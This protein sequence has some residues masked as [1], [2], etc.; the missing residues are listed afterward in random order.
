MKN[1]VIGHYEAV[2]L[3]TQVGKVLR[4]LGN[5]EPP[6]DLRTVREL[7]RLDRQYY[8]AAD[9]GVA[10]EVISYLKIAGKQIVARPTLLIDVIRK[11][12][13]AALWMPDQKRI[14]LDHD[15]PVLKH[16]WYESHE[17]GH[18]L[19][20]WHGEFLYGDSEETLSPV[21]RE[22]LEAEANYAAGQLLFMMDRFTAEAS[23]AAPTI[24]TVRQ[25][26]KRFGNTITSTLWR[27]VE[28]AHRGR[29]LFGVVTPSRKGAASLQEGQQGAR[30]Y[31]IEAPSFRERFGHSSER[32]LSELIDGYVIPRRGGPLGRAE[33]V[34]RDRNGDCHLFQFETFSNGHSLLT[35]GVYLR[36]VSPLVP[37]P[38]M[39]LLA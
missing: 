13:L 22:E 20:P 12:E 26:A 10:R 2:D 19:A 31:C 11:A 1:L 30:R 35:L 24:E 17:I 37:V 16:R 39:A 5:P 18:S 34:L 28:E 25:L 32:Q 38:E 27:F 3:R 9:T 23:D 8:S 15:T 36:P 4:G 7:L 21:C 14:L 33:I 29:P 6:L